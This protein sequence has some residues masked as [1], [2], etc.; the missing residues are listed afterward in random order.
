M[1]LVS[2]V[3]LVVAIALKLS[4]ETWEGGV[5]EG[6]NIQLWVTIPSL[7]TKQLDSLIRLDPFETTG[8]GQMMP[9]C[10][11]KHALSF[12]TT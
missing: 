10:G 5:E 7:M 4:I 12:F 6:E 9:F 1:V 2:V 8:N 3:T 11:Q